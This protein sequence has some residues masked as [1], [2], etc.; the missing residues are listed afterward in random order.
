MT[1]SC[2]MN[3]ESVVLNNKALLLVFGEEIIHALLKVF[4]GCMMVHAFEILAL[5]GRVRNVSVV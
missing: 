2:S 1:F 3:Y 5:G 4:K